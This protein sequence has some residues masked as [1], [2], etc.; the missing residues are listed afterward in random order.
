[1]GNAEEQQVGYA[2][3]YNVIALLVT[4]QTQKVIEKIE[5]DPTNTF[6]K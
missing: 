6:L 1:M 2:I 5:A 4:G 3:N